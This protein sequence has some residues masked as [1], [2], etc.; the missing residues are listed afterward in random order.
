MIES[1]CCKAIMFRKKCIPDYFRGAE[2]SPEIVLEYWGNLY[3]KYISL[4]IFLF[5]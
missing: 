5:H 4:F 1:K 2:P 3:E